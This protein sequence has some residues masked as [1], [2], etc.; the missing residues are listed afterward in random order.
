M[1]KPTWPNPVS[2]RVHKNV[3]LLIITSLLLSNKHINEILI[4]PKCS[5][6]PPSTIISVC[7]KEVE[8]LSLQMF[9]LTTIPF[10]RQHSFLVDIYISMHNDACLHMSKTPQLLFL[11]AKTQSIQST[12]SR[13]FDK[14]TT[15]KALWEVNKFASV[16]HCLYRPDF[17]KYSRS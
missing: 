16:D 3:R 7:N 1:T 8:D 6:F 12:E 5:C 15:A 13:Q 10:Y 14:M 4:Q 9:S 2:S 11:T 17:I